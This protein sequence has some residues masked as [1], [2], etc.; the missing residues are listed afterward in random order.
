MDVPVGSTLTV[1]EM[2]AEEYHC[3]DYCYDGVLINGEG[4]CRTDDD[5]DSFLHDA[6]KANVK[7]DTFVGMAL[8]TGKLGIFDDGG[9]STKAGMKMCW[10]TPSVD[11]ES[12]SSSSES[13]R[14]ESE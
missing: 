4:Y 11:A 10:S 3:G 9:D 2:Q 7:K 6:T 1:L 5:P 13:S 8:T 12:G 14:S